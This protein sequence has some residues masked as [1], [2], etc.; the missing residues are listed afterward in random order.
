MGIGVGIFFLAVGAILTF[1]VHATF[2]NVD[3]ATVGVILMIVGAL[4]LIIDLTI[5]MP[6]RRSIVATRSTGYADGYAPR[7]QTVVHEEQ[8]I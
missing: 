5:F 4:G 8:Q 6:R 3:I 1:A 7:S 2:N